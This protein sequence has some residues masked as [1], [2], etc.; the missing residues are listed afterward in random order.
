MLKIHLAWTFYLRFS[1][2]KT[3]SI[4]IFFV[5][6]HT[7]VMNHSNFLFRQMLKMRIKDAGGDAGSADH[8]LEH[9]KK[10]DSTCHMLDEDFSR[11]DCMSEKVEF[12]LYM[13][14]SV[15]INIIKQTFTG[16]MPK[17]SM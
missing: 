9:N 8:Q 6:C 11:D 4:K 14:I 5:L 10:T 16:K 12:L 7:F 2:L 13:I 1:G 15:N 17:S 3:I